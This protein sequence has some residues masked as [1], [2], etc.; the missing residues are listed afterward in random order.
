[1]NQNDG[2]PDDR[3]DMGTMLVTEGSVTIVK[4][5]ALV[6]IV[7]DAE[8]L[9]VRDQQVAARLHEFAEQS[10][11]GAE[12]ILPSVKELQIS[13]VNHRYDQQQFLLEF[14]K[15]LINNTRIGPE[16]IVMGMDSRTIT[17]VHDGKRSGRSR[18]APLGII[19]TLSEYLFGL[20]T[21]EEINRVNKI[22]SN[23]TSVQTKTLARLN[24]ITQVQGL[25]STKLEQL[26]AAQLGVIGTVAKLNGHMSQLSKNISENTFRLMVEHE[27]ARFSE[28]INARFHRAEQ[29]FVGAIAEG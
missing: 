23:I 21:E 29:G 20:C 5:V 8:V 9:L 28:G 1:M 2:V 27:F 4:D 25:E 18:R 26:R 15:D 11:N 14:Q 13:V 24:V 16:N 12:Y 3:L 17:G 7:I 22:L 10:V 6:P 19:G